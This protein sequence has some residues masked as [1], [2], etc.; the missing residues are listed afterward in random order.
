MTNN[1]DQFQGGL[2]LV[3]QYFVFTQVPIPIGHPARQGVQRLD[4]LD[5]AR[6]DSNVKMMHLP[7]E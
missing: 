5:E 1:E 6:A 2:V 3:M 4:Q 7:I